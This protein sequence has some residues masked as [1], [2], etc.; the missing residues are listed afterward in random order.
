MA[1]ITGESWKIF[2]K[3]IIRQIGVQFL[4]TEYFRIKMCTKIDQND[5]ITI[6]HE[7]K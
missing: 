3:R 4:E 2:F 1:R 7:A 6:H 5:F